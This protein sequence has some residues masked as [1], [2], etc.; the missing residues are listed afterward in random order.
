MIPRI[1]RTKDWETQFEKWI[2]YTKGYGDISNSLGNAIRVWFWYI[3]VPARIS[4]WT[5]KRWKNRLK[6]TED[7]G[8]E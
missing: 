4:F 1:R 3:G 7:E 2:T 5:W 6:D 8:S